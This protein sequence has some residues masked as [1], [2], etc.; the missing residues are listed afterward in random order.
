MGHP[1]QLDYTQKAVETLPRPKVR[2]WQY[3]TL[4]ELAIARS[5]W[6]TSGGLCD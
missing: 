4:I 3:S 5:D 2:D 1:P 6:L